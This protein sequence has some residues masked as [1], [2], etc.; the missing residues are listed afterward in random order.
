MNQLDALNHAPTLKMFL[1]KL[2]S[3]ASKLRYIAMESELRTKKKFE[4]EIVATFMT[5]Q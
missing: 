3:K 5:A 4:L 2:P 1:A